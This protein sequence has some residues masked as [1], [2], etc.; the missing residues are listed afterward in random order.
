MYLTVDDNV[1]L[2][3]KS[4][5]LV[6]NLDMSG[7]YHVNYDENNWRAIILQLRVDKDVT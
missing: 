3:N 2:A 7:F 1:L 4:H 6:A 5:F